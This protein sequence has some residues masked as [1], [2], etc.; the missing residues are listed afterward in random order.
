MKAPVF[1]VSVGDVIAEKYCVERILG[2]G[3]M[4]FVVSAKHLQLEEHFA[5]K[6]LNKDFLGQKSVVER[7]TREAR[8]ACK[9]RSEH[10]ARVYDVGV[11]DGAPFLVMEHLVGRDLGTVLGDGGRLRIEDAVEYTMHACEALAVAHSNGIVHRDIKPENL[12]LVEDEGGLPVVKLLDFGISKIALTDIESEREGSA[13]TGT[14]TLG[15][16]CYMSPEQIRSTA[17]ADGGSDLWSLGI[18]L[19]ELL[20]GCAAFKA[21]T[22]TE[23]CAA[24]LEQEPV[25]IRELRVE[26]PPELAGVVVRCLEKD[27]ARRYANVAELAVALLPFAPSR[28]LDSAERASSVLHGS[29]PGLLVREPVT[30][31][32]PSATP[33]HAQTRDAHGT[34]VS[35]A[36][37]AR[38]LVPTGTLVVPT[39]S[40]AVAPAGVKPARKRWGVVAIL[41]VC[42]ALAVGNLAAYRVFGPRASVAA[43]APAIATPPPDESAIPPVTPPAEKSAAA[44]AVQAL[45]EPVSIVVAPAR[46]GSRTPVHVVPPRPGPPPPRAPSSSAAAVAD[47]AAPPASAEPP[48]PSRLDIGY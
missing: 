17:S 30:G 47:A 6:F 11:H 35:G 39:P 26:V 36:P 25:P 42:A 5:L 13:L 18:V 43:R 21:D 38:S 41:S 45:P 16:P 28:A 1:Y 8:A 40:G 32:R 10:V 44:A 15:T 23:V 22:V 7:F 12:F 4:G 34:P 2:V 20:T 14:L 33:R 31:P 46:P 9:I 27:P 3:G 48:K 19:Y 37:L 24:V 29:R